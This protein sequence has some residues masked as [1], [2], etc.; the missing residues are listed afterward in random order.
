MPAIC[1]IRADFDRDSIVVYQAFPQA[2]A[3]AAL[4]AGAFVPPFSLER[5]TWIK[6]SFLWL[7]ERSNW[8]RKSGQEHILAV[9]MTR[10]GW[11][12]ALA[13]GVLTHPEP[14]IH[15]DA[16][17]WRASFDAATVHIQWD[18]ERSLR[19]TSLEH[20][21][22]QVGISRHLIRRYVD[23]WVIEITDRTPLVRKIHGL[24]QGGNTEAA[25]RL[26]PSERVYSVA[27]EIGRRI[28]I[29]E[30]AA[31]ERF[32]SGRRSPRTQS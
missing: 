24:M 22:I 15:G 4:R 26:L 12:E 31:S 19:G 3:D 1:E 9:R 32:R 10:A 18:P 8:G 6:P 17:R 20:R 27:P 13:L 16:D 21:T 11:D 14:T 25:K 5:M 7:M 29:T 30:D 28:G 23:K 2:I